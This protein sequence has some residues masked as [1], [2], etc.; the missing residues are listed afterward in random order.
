MFN[1]ISGA[2]ADIRDIVFRG[3]RS[4]VAP[5]ETRTALVAFSM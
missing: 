5:F 1:L 2:A 4:Q 3:R